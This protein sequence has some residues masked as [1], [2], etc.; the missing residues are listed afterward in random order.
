[1]PNSFSTVGAMSYMLL[2]AYRDPEV[3]PTRELEA[4][5]RMNMPFSAWLQSSGPVSFS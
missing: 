3:A 5:L 4:D 1:M 2:T